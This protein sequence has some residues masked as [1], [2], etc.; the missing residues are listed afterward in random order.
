MIAP[1]IAAAAVVTAAVAAQP[2]F[3]DF[4]SEAPGVVHRIAVRD[5]PAPFATEPASNAPIL[6]ERP[7]NAVP[8]APPGFKVELYAENL[9]QPRVIR[10]APNGDLFVAE[11]G[12]GRIRVFRGIGADGKPRQSSI[13]ADGLANAYGIAFFPVGANPQWVYIGG[14][15][16]V[17]RFPYR[18]GALQADGSPEKI[19]DLPATGGHWTRDLS[20][21]RDGRTLF[22][23]VGSASNIDDPDTSPAEKFRADILAFDPDG[24][25]QRI[26]AS[27]IR[28][29]SG[30]ALDPITGQLWCVAN[31]RDG[32]G[33][34]LVPDYLTAVRE[35]GFYGWPWWYLGAH[36]DP[37]H[38]GKHPELRSKVI[39]PDVLL[40]P[41]SAPL[42]L[43]FY[44][45]ERFPR[46]YTGDIFA[47]F[48]GS[49]NRAARTGYEVIRVPRQPS[50]RA[51]GEYQ[52]FLTGF[53]L[54]NGQV[55]GRP[56]GVATAS[57][58]SLLV[59]DDASNTI[60][61]VDYVGTR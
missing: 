1:S 15:D 7:R 16:A 42:Q 5:L 9:A 55:W 44:G 29:P 11:T 36:Q 49:W 41:H 57:D 3:Y 22:V 19:V 58:G 39:V 17:W 43:N 47:T 45:G 2:P 6:V 46:E 18:N 4:R 12:R 25:H 52:D 51:R 30:I 23:A 34:N 27:G 53:A 35:G 13:F 21:S 59:S 50:G 26:Y 40:Q 31:E 54:P 24:R 38:A 10:V 33:D 60:W 61:R 28:N 48:H 32:L 20:F 14:N 56:V 37:R 8:R